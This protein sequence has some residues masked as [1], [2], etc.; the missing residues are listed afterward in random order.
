[1][2]R[3]PINL[4]RLNQLSSKLSDH[5][6]PRALQYEV[7]EKC[8]L[9]GKVLDYGGGDQSLYK[10]LLKCDSYSSVNI[11]PKISPTWTI[12]VGDPVPCDDETFDTV[13]SFN[14]LEHIYDTKSVLSELSRVLSP[15]G[16]LFLTVPFLFPIH[17]HPDD[18]F[19]PTPSW[20]HCMAEEMGFS[21][22]EIIPLSWGPYTAAMTITGLPGPLKNLRKRWALWLDLLY[23][24]LRMQKASEAEVSIYLDRYATAFF[25]RARKN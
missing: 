17:G 21:E 22:V 10:S 4:T 20:Y 9:K 19:R 8:T 1:M 3:L 7:L 23:F 12:Q 24:K 11:D 18:F 25:V 2:S 5:S 6:L 13:I 14:T 16:E 15:G